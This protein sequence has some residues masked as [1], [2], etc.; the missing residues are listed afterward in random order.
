[1][2]TRL[3]RGILVLSI[4]VAATADLP[5]QAETAHW[6]SGV[7]DK[8]RLSATWSASDLN[9]L[10]RGLR[11]ASSPHEI[12]LLAESSWLGADTSRAAASSELASRLGVAKAWARP[13]ST[14]VLPT[15]DPG[16]HGELLVRHGI[17]AVRTATPAAKGRALQVQATRFGLWH[18]PLMLTVPQLGWSLGGGMLQLRKRLNRVVTEQG[19]LHAAI[20][21]T[22]LAASSNWTRWRLERT[23]QGASQRQSQGLLEILP[24]QA[25]VARLTQQQQGQPSRSILR[26]AA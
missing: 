4:D 14:V 21:L 20:D 7:L 26:P 24:M 19:L 11:D 23:L 5:R 6:L 1:M 18:V 2:S 15:A 9:M 8:L 22:K 3:S 17:R 10:P 13:I 12:A 25:I 16:M